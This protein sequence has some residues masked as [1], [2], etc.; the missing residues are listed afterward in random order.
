MPQSAREHPDSETL[1]VL[2]VDCGEAAPRTICSGL[3]ATHKQA[4]LEGIDV[5]VLTNGKK[6]EFAGVASDGMVL[7]G[8]KKKKPLTL[9]TVAGKV[10]PGTPCLPQGYTVR[11]T[12]T[13]HIHAHTS[14]TL[15]PLP[16]PSPPPQCE[17]VVDFDI[18]GQF[19]KLEFKTDKEG[20]VLFEGHALEA[21]GAAVQA[22]GISNGKIK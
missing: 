2:E 16:P 20:C 22:I 8:D 18:R 21:A 10:K 3:R 9:L 11:R 12:A 5:V 14:T 1:F 4:D 13:A 17:P 15:P 19:K 6:T 7:S